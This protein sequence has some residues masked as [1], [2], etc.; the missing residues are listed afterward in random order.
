MP[1]PNVLI[2]PG[3]GNT[4][5]TG[6]PPKKMCL[7]FIYPHPIC[8]LPKQLTLYGLI[9]TMRSIVTSISSLKDQLLKDKGVFLYSRA[10][11]DCHCALTLFFNAINFLTYGKSNKMLE[12]RENRTRRLLQADKKEGR[13]YCP[14]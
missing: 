9:M 2:Q 8:N 11:V 10:K 3:N 13:H 6:Y 4:S 1:S 5:S 7:I 12:M 14:S